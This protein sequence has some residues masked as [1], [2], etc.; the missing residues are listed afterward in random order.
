[1]GKELNQNNLSFLNSNIQEK[2]EEDE[3]SALT[4]FEFNQQEELNSN[5]NLSEYCI[6][7]DADT[8]KMD[9]DQQVSIPKLSE[10]I[11]DAGN[12]EEESEK[13]LKK[14]KLE[15]DA[16]DNEQKEEKDHEEEEEGEGEETI[17]AHED[18]GD[19]GENADDE[20]EDD[21]EAIKVKQDT[22]KA[23][24]QPSLI[25]TI[26]Q[27][28]AMEEEEEQ[29]ESEE[30]RPKEE[31]EESNKNILDVEDEKNLISES[32][33]EEEEL[34][35]Q[36]EEET[37]IDFENK[38]LEALN[39]ITD[40]EYKFAELRQKLY[41]NKL[42]KLETELQMCLEGTHP[43]LQ[44][45]YSKIASIRDNKLRKA[46][47]RQKYELS[48]ID[49]ETKAS[50]IFIHQNFYKNVNDLKNHLLNETTQEWYDI[51]KERRDIDV[52][53][54]DINYHVPI[55][56]SKKTLSCITGYAGAAQA[57]LPGEPISE[58]LEVENIKF[59]YKNNPVDKLEVIVDRMR[60][61][62]HLSDLE[63]LKRYYSAFPGA[64]N[65]SSLRDS[66]INDDFQELANLTH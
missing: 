65:L 58:D 43:E 7:S 55:K 33:P 23:D 8:E 15:T 19:E 3:E 4:N 16:I 14:R 49:K 45:Y 36:D 25:E 31:K 48:C 38:R 50:R 39:D 20:D 54:P 26:S 11:Q 66:E 6:S 37:A 27:E 13:I 62:N 18:G 61:N 35:E 17:H 41:D 30:E 10:L 42:L 22:T 34:K 9:S 63:G 24:E 46:Y 12:E 5:L 1:M 59:R 28:H 40:I 32:T 47:Q 53:V 57:R 21:D 51:N 29:K 44:K 64:P 60:L 2:K 56:T 52:I